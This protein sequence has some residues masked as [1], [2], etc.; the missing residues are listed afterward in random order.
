LIEAR[1]KH[2]DFSIAPH[3]HYAG[4]AP[5][6]RRSDRPLVGDK[7]KL[8]GFDLISMRPD[9][10]E[11]RGIRIFRVLD[12]SH[13][14]VTPEQSQKQMPFAALPQCREILDVR[15][16]IQT[17]PGPPEPLGSSPLLKIIEAHFRLP[18][19]A[20][21][22]VVTL[23]RWERKPSSHGYAVTVQSAHKARPIGS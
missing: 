5:K 15:F 16:N 7:W 4:K 14:D 20:G 2:Q 17:N 8:V 1:V 10:S 11:E 9:L 19:I 22:Q 13:C 23:F 12:A 18:T 3:I 6:D 21:I